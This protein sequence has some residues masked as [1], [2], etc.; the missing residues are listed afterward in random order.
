MGAVFVVLVLAPAVG[1]PVL[2]GYQQERLTS[3]VNSDC[4]PSDPCYQTNQALIAIGS[5]GKTGLGDD[6]TQ[7][8]AGFL[9]EAA[10]TSSSPSRRS[11]GVSSAPRSYCPF[12]PC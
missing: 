6:A 10:R 5:G 3:F 8:R 9:P 7:A 2:E 12:T 11:A 4:D 1:A